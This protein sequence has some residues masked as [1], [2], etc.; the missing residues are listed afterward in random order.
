MR[1]SNEK[2]NLIT[3]LVLSGGG[4]KVTLYRALFKALEENNIIN[5]ITN[6]SGSSGGAIYALFLCIGMNHREIKKMESDFNIL[7]MVGAY[8]VN[9]LSQEF[10]PNF[11][12]RNLFSFFFF[13]QELSRFFNT[14]GLFEVNGGVKFIRNLLKQKIGNPDI[15]FRQLYFLANIFPNRFKNL[16]VTGT[17]LDISSISHKEKVFSYIT[18]PEMRI[19]DALDITVRFPLFFAPK[20]VN[21]NGKLYCWVDGGVARNIPVNNFNP[22]KTLVACFKRNRKVNF[23]DPKLF[24]L[25]YLYAIFR[26]RE[27]LEVSTIHMLY[28]NLVF[29]D[30]LNISVLQNAPKD[31]IPSLMA[32]T[33]KNTLEQLSSLNLIKCDKSDLDITN[34]S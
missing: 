24:L 29:I 16:Y 9:K 11:I 6:V 25:R 20:K 23:I 4:Y 31:Q 5:K 12:T 10:N 7:T 28:K 30:P 33:Y 2:D 15:T 19:V 34:Q 21:I 14:G 17:L 22:E 27:Q 13:I 1:K 26:A 3:N 32:N 18:T 8:S